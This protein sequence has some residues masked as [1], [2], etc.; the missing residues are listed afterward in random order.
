MT[1]DFSFKKQKL[2]HEWVAWSLIQAEFSD[3]NGGTFTRTYVNS[4]GAVGVVAMIGDT[5]ERNVLLVRQY[6]PA[7]RKHTLE[8]PAGMRDKTDED[9]QVTALRELEEETGYFAKS[10]IFIGSHESAPGISNSLVDLFLA[11]DLVK[12]KVDRHGPEEQF[13]TVETH[14]FA[15]SLEMIKT[16][17]ITDGKTVIGLLSVAANFSQYL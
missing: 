4:P 8:I 17:E 6:R 16:G 5:S 11:V 13:M 3:P 1:A 15:K 2:I 9:S 12:T 10:L 7:F 14:S